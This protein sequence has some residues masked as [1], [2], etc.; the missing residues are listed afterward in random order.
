M[1]RLRRDST[2]SVLPKTVWGWVAFVCFVAFF[3]VFIV[4]LR[5][6]TP[7][8]AWLSVVIYLAGLVLGIFASL[9]KRDTSI[10]S[11]VIGAIG[12]AI[13]PM[14]LEFLIAGTFR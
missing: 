14:W 7:I 5:F 9:R 2:V 11:G 4:S 13:M 12:L 10:L 8:V 3:V 1:N 6:S